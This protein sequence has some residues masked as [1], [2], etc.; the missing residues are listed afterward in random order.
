M[1]GSG[2]SGAQIAEELYQSGRK[3]FLATG[4]APHAPRRYRGKDIFRWMVDSGFSNQAY[5][6]MQFFGRSFVAPMIT[7]KD[8]GHS[9]NLHKFYRE[10]VILLG[11]G[12]DYV[13]G[14]MI[15]APDLKENLNKADAGQVQIMKYFDDYIQRAGLNAPL[16]NLPVM[17]DGYQAQEITELDLHM[18]GINTIIWACGYAYASEIFKMPVLNSFGFPDAPQGDSKTY[19]GLYFVGFPCPTLISA[20][21]GGVAQCGAS[22]AEKIRGKQSR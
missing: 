6:K 9:L 3:V 14:K 11:H 13:D 1:A 18:E 20:H 10:G 8:G 19:P 16:E 21:F 7:G 2:Q 15:F 5:E 22:V 12:L 17:S 4:T